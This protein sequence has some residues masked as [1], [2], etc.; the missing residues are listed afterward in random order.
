MYKTLAELVEALV[1][2]TGKLKLLTL[3][4]AQ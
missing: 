2:C 4:R 3:R 1:L